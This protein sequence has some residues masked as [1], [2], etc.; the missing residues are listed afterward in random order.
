MISLDNDKILANIQDYDLARQLKMHVFTKIKSTNSFLKTITREYGID[1]CCAEQ[2]NQG[3]GRLNRKWHSPKSENIYLSY[4]FVV[5]NISSK[6]SAISLVTGLAIIE[7][8]KSF[9]IINDIKIK[10]P[11]D[12]YWQNKK[13]AGILIESTQLPEKKISVVIGI[14]LNVNSSFKEQIDRPWASLFDICT[15]KFDR[16]III[17]ELINNLTANIRILQQDGFQQFLEQWQKVDYLYTKDITVK[18]FNSELTG[19][20][21]GV[22]PT[23]NLILNSLD[24][25][26]HILNYGETSIKKMP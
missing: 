21:A 12:I 8:L 9:N 16:N 17:A 1:I 10:W 15:Q 22:D 26:Q 18:H 25:S 6:I 14:G 13:L 7:T 19:I 2:Q 24:G 23:G 5:H 4:R 20:C 3:R 11:N